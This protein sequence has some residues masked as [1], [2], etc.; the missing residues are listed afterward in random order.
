[1]ENF[2]TDM[3][4]IRKNQSEKSMVWEIKNYFNGFMSRCDTSKEGMSELKIGH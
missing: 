4:N 1:M 3:E 2:I